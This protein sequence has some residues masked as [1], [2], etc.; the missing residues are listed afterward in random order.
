MGRYETSVMA[1]MLKF[2]LNTSKI[3]LSDLDIPEWFDECHIRLKFIPADVCDLERKQKPAYNKLLA[4]EL[5]EARLLKYHRDTIDIISKQITEMGFIN[6]YQDDD[7]HVLGEIMVYPKDNN[8]SCKCKGH[9]M[10]QV[11]ATSES[12][13]KTL[14]WDIKNLSNY[15]ELKR[16]FDERGYSLTEEPEFTTVEYVE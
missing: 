12:V 4:K 2:K 10:Q 8:I 15:E 9:I 7:H 13:K 6:G 11:W 5:D 1:Y 3:F 14:K 16:L